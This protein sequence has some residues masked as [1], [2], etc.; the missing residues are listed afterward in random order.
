MRQRTSLQ[1]TRQG[2][3]YDAIHHVVLSVRIAVTIDK[4]L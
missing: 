4:A 2:I 3:V 1:N